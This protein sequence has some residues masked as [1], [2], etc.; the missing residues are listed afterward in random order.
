MK[1]ISLDRDGTQ[2]MTRK[3]SCSDSAERSH[4]A[5]DCSSPFFLG[6]SFAANSRNLQ[7]IHQS[8][9]SDKV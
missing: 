1:D 4:E 5:R 8:Q 7:Y 9:V 3:L 2:K 6:F